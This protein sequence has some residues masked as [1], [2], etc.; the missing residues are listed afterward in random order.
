MVTNSGA[1]PCTRC[2]AEPRV[3]R[4]RWCR[5]CRIAYARTRRQAMKALGPLLP[6]QLPHV[7]IQLA[8]AEDQDALA[9]YMAKGAALDMLRHLLHFAVERIRAERYV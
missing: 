4:Q 1:R 2:G 7:I 3:S 8:R 5:P 9:R 6:S